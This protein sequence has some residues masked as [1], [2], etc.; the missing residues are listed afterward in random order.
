M[1][2]RERISNARDLIQSGRLANEAAVSSGVVLPILDALGWP[3]FDPSIVAPEYGVAKRRVDFAL[4]TKD[5]PAVFVE[6]KQPGLA[7]G[8]DRQLFEYAFH[9]GVPI[10]VLTDGATWHVYLPAMQ[11]TYD[12]RRVYLL[13]LLERSPSE[14]AKQLER[15]LGREAVESGDAFERARRDYQSARQRKGAAA[16]IPQA[17]FNIISEPSN[18]LYEMLAQEVESVSGFS[19]NMEDLTNFVSSLKPGAGSLP[20]GKRRKKTTQHRKS[21]P[22]K[23]NS[24]AD[25]GSLESVGFEVKGEF[26]K[27]NQGRDVIAGVFE[28]LGKHD[29]T[30]FERFAALPKHGRKRRYLARSKELLYP[31]H[32]ELHPQSVKVGKEWWLATHYSSAMKERIIAS[33]CKVAGLEFGKDVKVRMP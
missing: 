9:E 18:D 10:A 33:A 7:N 31:G 8:A 3:A 22:G 4:L 14:S 20:R 16:A 28:E 24:N 32:P 25:A 26:K 12:E 11:G 30:F 2:L 13:D 5:T 6:V 15:Y 27:R 17:W 29:P 19:P 23:P 1:S 21:S